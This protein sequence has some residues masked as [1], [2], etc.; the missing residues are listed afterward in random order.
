MSIIIYRIIILQVK[1]I[2]MMHVFDKKYYGCF[3]SMQNEK[4]KGRG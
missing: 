1:K 2:Y 3:D 4:L